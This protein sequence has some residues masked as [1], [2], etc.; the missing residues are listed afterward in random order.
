MLDD[1]DYKFASDV[2]DEVLERV[3]RHLPNDGL[4]RAAVYRKI[5]S[6]CN[7]MAADL[8]FDVAEGVEE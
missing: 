6:E 2:I 1:K 7:L 5:A 8:A 3:W 4:R